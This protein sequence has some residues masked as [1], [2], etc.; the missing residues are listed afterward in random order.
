MSS[1][2][3]YD[4]VELLKYK[5]T[6]YLENNKSSGS[7]LKYIKDKQHG[8]P[9]YLLCTPE[10]LEYIKVHLG[11][12]ELAE[13]VSVISALK[14]VVAEV[15]FRAAFD[16]DSWVKIT[17]ILVTNYDFANDIT[18]PHHTPPGTHPGL[19]AKVSLLAS[20]P[21]ILMILILENYALV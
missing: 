5:L 21:E 12:I 16:T 1:Q 6:D 3:N 17:R 13:G 10:G 7:L 20:Y 19:L 18:Y 8:N 15:G 14:Q 9:T 11:Q 4:L 2:N